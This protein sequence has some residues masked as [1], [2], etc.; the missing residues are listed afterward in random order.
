MLTY[1]ID[2]HYKLGNAVARLQALSLECIEQTKGRKD[3]QQLADVKARQFDKPKTWRMCQFDDAGGGMA[4]VHFRVQG[5]IAGKELPPLSSNGNIIQLKKGRRYL[6]QNIKLFGGKSDV[7]ADAAHATEKAYVQ[8]AGHF[9]DGT[10]E[11]W[12][13]GTRGGDPIIEANT[14][15]LTPKVLCSDESAEKLDEYI[16]PQG[17]LQK[18]M[19]DDFVYGPDNKVEYMERI[20]N[21]D[22]I[23]KVSPTQFKIGDIVEAVVAF[24]CYQTQKGPIKM[25]IALRAL[26]LLDHTE[27]DEAAVLRMRNK[28]KTTGGMGSISTLKRKSAYAHEDTEE[29]GMR[30]ARMRIDD[31][32]NTVPGQEARFVVKIDIDLLFKIMDELELPKELIYLGMTCNHF[33]MALKKRLQSNTYKYATAHGVEFP[34]WIMKKLEHTNSIIAGPDVLSVWM[35]IP[36]L[37]DRLEIFCPNDP[38]A[39]TAVI[40]HLTDTEGFEVINVVNPGPKS[41]AE[42]REVYRDMEFGKTVHAIVGLTKVD[43]GRGKDHG[44]IVVIS[45][46]PDTPIITVTEMMTTIFMNFITGSAVV[47]LYPCYTF[48]GEGLMNYDGPV[49]PEAMDITALFKRAGM[50]LKNTARGI[51]DH[52]C[53]SHHLCPNTIRHFTDNR[54]FCINIGNNQTTV[55]QPAILSK[56]LVYWRLRCGGMC[57]EKIPEAIQT[58]SIAI[59]YGTTNYTYGEY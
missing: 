8:F 39:F 55:L 33:R 42:F 13:L 10:M 38:L 16:D 7:F 24:V 23:R 43:K 41:S 28:Q 22:G 51:A 27:Q 35:N 11:G 37:T 9:A 36:S 32:D 44:C 49:A 15:Y 6:R 54:S 31:D 47:C 26:S 18:I 48:Y 20:S 25:S 30:F 2:E 34:D 12:E 4:G 59:I 45:K 50:K 53:G 40:D 58:E 56:P 19:E 46:S 57:G 29:A 14:R 52:K 21:Q 5:I 1:A 3:V 17:V